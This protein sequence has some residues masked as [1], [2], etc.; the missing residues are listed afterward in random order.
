MEQLISVIPALP[1]LSA[2]LILLLPKLLAHRAAWISTSATFITFVLTIAILGLEIAGKDIG[3]VDTSREWGVLL[4]D[5]L[6]AIMAVLI[7]GISLIVHIYSIR[8]MAE[9]P[10][11]ARF[12]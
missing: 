11:Y 1:I 4:S 2:I 9:E 7:A 8:Y 5:P 6:S 10:G 12:L 3:Q